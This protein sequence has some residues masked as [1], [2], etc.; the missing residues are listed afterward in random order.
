MEASR[1]WEEKCGL[2]Y[3]QEWQVGE[4][5]PVNNTDDGGWGLE[6]SL[7]AYVLKL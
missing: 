7:R 5:P 1:G 4:T 3:R 2:L 6:L